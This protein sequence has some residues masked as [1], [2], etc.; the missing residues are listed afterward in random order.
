MTPPTEGKP[1]QPAATR[2]ALEPLVLELLGTRKRDHEGVLE[3]HRKLV[4]ASPDLHR[5]LLAWLADREPDSVHL[6][7][8]L[9][10]A[11]TSPDQQGRRFARALLAHLPFTVMAD[12]IDYIHGWFV[13]HVHRR[14]ERRRYADEMS[15]AYAASAG[16]VR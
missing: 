14:E 1:I 3:A 4:A 16:V 5:R 2:S 9:A 15:R 10:L 12:V 13:D 8:G 7:V 11:A 6:V